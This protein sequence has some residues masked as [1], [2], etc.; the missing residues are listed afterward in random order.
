MSRSLAG[1]QC[2]C[3]TVLR[4][5]RS[6]TGE[7]LPYMTGEGVMPQGSSQAVSACAGR[8]WVGDLAI[9]ER[10]NEW[11]EATRTGRTGTVSIDSPTSLEVKLTP[12]P[13]ARTPT[14]ARA[15]ALAESRGAGRRYRRETET[16]SEYEAAL[17]RLPRNAST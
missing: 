8:P 3:V 12:H 2:Q 1:R 13:T 9:A 5:P 10:P 14:P 15:R 17:T 11:A 16:L 6:R 7:P 4:F